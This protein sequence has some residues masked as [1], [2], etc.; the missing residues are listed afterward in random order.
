[1]RKRFGI[2]LFAFGAALILG[3][4]GH[5]LAQPANCGDVNGDGQI[6]TGDLSALQAGTISPACSATNCAD[7]NGVGGVESGDQVILSRFLAGGGTMV[8]PGRSRGEQNLLFK[9]CTAAPAAVACNSAGTALTGRFTSNLTIPGPGDGCSEFFI[10][11]KITIANNSTLTIRPGALVK[12]IKNPADPAMIL[13]TRGAH[14]NANGATNPII[15]TSAENPGTRAPGDWGGVIINGFAPENF[16]GEGSS[17]GLPPRADSAYGG[18]NPNA[19]TAVLR[20]V[21]I[22]F[23]GVVIGEANELNIL[24]QN[25]MGRLSQLDHVQTN[26][27]LD[28]CFEWFGGNVRGKFLVATACGDDGLDWQIGY[29]GAGDPAPPQPAIQFALVTHDS[30][31]VGS[32]PDAHGIEADNSEFGAAL[33]PRSAPWLCNITAVGTRDTGGPQ[34]DTG[35]GARLRRGTAG[36][37]ENSI[38]ENWRSNGLD[39]RDGS[40]IDIAPDVLLFNDGATPCT[41]SGECADAT[42]TVAS[43]LVGPLQYAGNVA[44]YC[45]ASGVLADNRYFA[46]PGVIGTG[47]ADDC[48]AADPFFDSAPYPGAFDGTT[49]WL[50]SIKPCCPSGNPYAT[51]SGQR[52][53]VS[54]DKN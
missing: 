4:A 13:I 33:Q 53:W 8:E 6:T 5:A 34:T 27:G 26:R 1:M 18:D 11:G 42:V 22:E 54:F 24:T 40:P 16:V 30:A 15:L 9:L 10:K 45:N 3:G 41:G 20:F 21:R 52:C 23:S 31:S 50:T 46:T 37:L 28:D 29:Q 14:L 48:A 47:S 36:R 17:E 49:N 51:F 44:G 39:I 19:F 35:D 2:A 7:V 32:D 12:A 25:A 38:L 43:S